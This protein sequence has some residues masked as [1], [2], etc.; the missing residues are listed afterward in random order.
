MKQYI[1]NAVYP[2]K[3]ML[4]TIQSDIIQLMHSFSVNIGI[5][6]PENNDV[7]RGETDVNITFEG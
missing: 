2:D 3:V 6:Q 5:C 4:L 1:Y 7:H